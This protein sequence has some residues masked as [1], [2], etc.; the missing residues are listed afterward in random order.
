[1]SSFFAK[2]FGKLVFEKRTLAILSQDELADKCKNTGMNKSRISDIEKAKIA[3]PQSA[4]IRELVRVLGIT[5]EEL[6]ECYGIGVDDDVLPL[7]LLQDIAESFG[8]Q[9]PSAS[10]AELLAYLKQTAK[11][12]HSLRA[13]LAELE[14]A[15]DNLSNMLA[16]AQDL[17]VAQDYKGVEDL[18]APALEIQTGERLRKEAEKAAKIAQA[19]A[20]AALLDGRSDDATKHIIRAAD[21]VTGY[22]TDLG[23]IM[24]NSFA[25]RLAGHA[26]AF[27]GQ[28]AINAIT[29][30]EKNL[31]VWGFENDKQKWAMTQNNLANVLRDQA[32]RTE[33]ADA[34]ALLGRAVAAYEA[35]LEVRTRDDEPQ[36][37]A[38][39]QNNLAVALRDQA[40]RT[41]GA[42][43]TALL[44]RAV[45]AYEAALEVYTR[46]DEPQKWAM[47]Q[48]NLAVALGDQAARSEGA[49][50]TALLGRAVAAYEAALEVRTRDDEPQKWAMTQNNLANVLR[51][52]AARTEG[53]DA[54]ALLGRAVAAYEAALEVYTRDDEPQKWAMTQNN[55]AVA[56]RNQAACTEGAD[57]TALLGRA[58]AAYEAA[59]EVYTRDDEPQKWAMMQN[60]L[61]NVLR[62]QAARTEG[63]DATA[64]LGRAVAAYEAALE[65]YTRDDGPQNW[66]ETQGNLGSLFLQSVTVSRTPGQDLQRALQH[67]DAALE[68][69][70]PVHTSQYYVK[71]TNVRD[72]VLDL[73]VE[74]EGEA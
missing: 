22:D 62:D 44:G 51:D 54:T 26:R 18:L 29:L 74:F 37:W 19:M 60:N 33:G 59:L 25:I 21:F 2:K 64:L 41:E 8:D 47:T 27:G 24:R 9:K 23:A 42:D 7:K 35:A 65:V 38:M 67:L 30:Y 36:N 55:L 13:R 1:M 49:D 52:Q 11:D 5:K 17:M 6:A 70:D 39:T 28:G 20:D 66:A 40:A 71:C 69:Y 72:H 15:N 12:W 56:L 48:N 61:A 10:E 58:V 53:A 43:A 50:A 34:T 45:A 4:T 14:L 32:A 63:A 68:V 31:T 73:L 16:A 46:D 3:K 57:A